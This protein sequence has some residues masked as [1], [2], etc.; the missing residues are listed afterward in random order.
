VVTSGK[1]EFKTEAS[2]EEKECNGMKQK[3]DD[4][5]EINETC[6]SR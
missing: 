3:A 4:R 2:F 1:R 6:S 5:V